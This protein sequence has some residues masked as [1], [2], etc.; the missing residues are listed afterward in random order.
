ML[1]KRRVVPAGPFR[2]RAKL[3][4]GA[5]PTQRLQSL[6][7]RLAGRFPMPLVWPSRCPFPS[8]PTE[9]L[10]RQSKSCWM[11]CVRTST[12]GRVSLSG[13]VP[14]SAITQDLAP[15]L[16]SCSPHLKGRQKGGCFC[17]SEV[18]G[19]VS[20][21]YS[22]LHPQGRKPGC[23]VEGGR[24][25]FLLTQSTPTPVGPSLSSWEA[26]G[27]LRKIIINIRPNGSDGWESSQQV[28]SLFPE[29]GGVNTGL[30]QVSGVG[31]E[32]HPKA[33]VR[34]WSVNL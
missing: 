20:S 11:W 14:C 27:D 10:R 31:G 8:S 1:G 4:R 18:G 19:S 15:S 9:P 7:L 34:S 29:V 28:Y 23:Q 3:L 32:R 33:G 5:G 30:G 12:S 21:W 17:L 2:R 22:T 13:K 24:P 26:G 25:R 16:P 6:T